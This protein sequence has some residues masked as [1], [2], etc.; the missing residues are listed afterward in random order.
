MNFE[1]AILE[2]KNLHYSY[3]YDTVLENICFT[4]NKGDFLAIVGPNG[5]GKS[6]LL[7]L[8]LRLLK[9]QNGEILIYGKSIDLF[10]ELGKGWFCFSKSK[11]I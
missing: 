2:L 8:I 1:K 4:V 5:S 3:N 11:C 6:T 7:K 10:T 9:K